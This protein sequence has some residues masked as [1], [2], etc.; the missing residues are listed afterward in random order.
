M[1]KYFLLQQADIGMWLTQMTVM[2]IS[3]ILLWQLNSESMRLQHK[4]WQCNYQG[5]HASLKVLE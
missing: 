3:M 5:G 1:P 4:S 2:I